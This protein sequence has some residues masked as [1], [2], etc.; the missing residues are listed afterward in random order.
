MS[1]INIDSLLVPGKRAHL[2][3]IGGVSMRPLAEVLHGMGMQI[4]GSDMNESEAVASLRQLGIDVRIGHF[5]DSVTGAD[6]VIRTAAVHDDN[7]E[8]V[9]ARKQNVPVFERAQAWGSIMKSYKNALC[10]AG[11][12]GKTTTT[13]M[14]T[15]IFMEANCDPTVMI[16]GTL[17]LL[18]AGHRVGSGDTIILE[19]CEYCNSFWSFF[20]TIAVI[21]NVDADHLDFF[22]G[23]DDVINSFKHF[24]MQVPE[25][26]KVIVNSDDKNAMKAVAD[27]NRNIITFGLDSSADIQGT[28]LIMKN[29]CCCFDVLNNGRYYAHIQ[30]NVPGRHNALNALASVAAAITLGIPPAPVERALNSF[31]GAARRFEYKGEYKGAKIYDDYAHH[32]NEMRALITAAQGLG[33]DRIILVF[34]PH[35]YTRTKMLF[36]DFVRELR[37]VDIA[38]LAEIYAAR[39]VN[40]IGITSSQLAEAAGAQCYA[41]MDEIVVALQRLTRPGDLILT[42]GA[43]DIYKVGEKLASLK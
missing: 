28:N 9:S 6:L 8:I 21:L 39:E 41:S 24:A 16:G 43:G 1:S 13:S 4:T 33:Y 5:A 3:G 40:T 15:C 36:N 23:L 27:I 18:H 19:S 20:P 22:S 29:G 35:T 14:S 38:I 11:T 30:L 37:R 17:P 2:V 32:P 26:G 10:I 31:S 42:V 25:N 12:H 34:Q 7:P